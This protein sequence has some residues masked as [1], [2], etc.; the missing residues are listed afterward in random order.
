M[1]GVVE[2]NSVTLRNT[3]WSLLRVIAG[4]VGL[5]LVAFPLQVLRH[6]LQGSF[7]WLG[8]ILGS[9]FGSGAV[10]CWWFAW[11]GQFADSRTIMCHSLLG[12]LIL[13]GI[14][15]SAGFFGPMILTPSSNQGPLVGIFITGPIGFVSGVLFG[16]IAGFL[17]IR[18]GKR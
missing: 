16:S 12:G 7:D 5:L 1:G 10:M 14:S 2:A 17:R 18:R 4:F 11:R 9:V 6:Q 3:S 15:F 13:G 8:V